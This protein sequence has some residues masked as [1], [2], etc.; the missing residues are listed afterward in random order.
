[1]YTIFTAD[2][3]RVGKRHD[4]MES[5]EDAARKLANRYRLCRQYSG[6]GGG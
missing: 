2:D 6:K 5:A 3:R 1:M 4:T